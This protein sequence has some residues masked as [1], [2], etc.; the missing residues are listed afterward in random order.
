MKLTRATADRFGEVWRRCVTSPPSPDPA[1]V[2][3]DLRER[4]SAAGREFH[5]LGH[6]DDCLRHFDEIAPR[7]MDRDAVEIALW[8]HDA[9]YEPGNPDNERRSAQLF[10]EQSKG[11][12]AA[13]PASRLC[14]DS[15]DAARP[16]STQRRLQVHRRHRPCR[17]RFAVEGLHAQRPQAAAG[18][19]DAE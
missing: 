2:Y 3:A 16:D 9:V 11:A 7:L 4:L 17:L 14:A 19:L 1:A 10:L 5:N 12:P 6:I 13:V 15:H 18:I 8:F